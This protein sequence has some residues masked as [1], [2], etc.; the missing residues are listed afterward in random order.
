M[1]Y[2]INENQYKKFLLKEGTKTTDGFVDLG[3]KDVIGILSPNGTV[4]TVPKGTRITSLYDGSDSAFQEHRQDCIEFYEKYNQ[5]WEEWCQKTKSDSDKKY[6][7]NLGFGPTVVTFV[8]PDGKRFG[9]ILTNPDLNAAKDNT[10]IK[11]DTWK[12]SR[13]FDSKNRSDFKDAKE[14]DASDKESPFKAPVMM[15]DYDGELSTPQP[16]G[17]SSTNTDNNSTNK[18]YS[19]SDLASDITKSALG[20]AGGK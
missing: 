8:Q 12:W 9:S 16:T 11:T 14:S 13:Y 3:K 17:N 19:G 1:K 20:V 2:I 10:N 7:F 5:G 15:G 4:R 6:G 18:G